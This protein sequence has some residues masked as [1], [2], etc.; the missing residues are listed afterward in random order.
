VLTEVV[1][2]LRALPETEDFWS[3]LMPGWQEGLETARTIVQQGIALSMLRL[4]DPTE[5]SISLVMA[6]PDRGR[7]Y[8]DA[9][10]SRRGF[11]EEKCL[12]VLAA[13]GSASEV[14]HV[15][16]LT[17][18]I[19]RQNGGMVIGRLVGREWKKSR[20]QMP[21]LRDSLWEAGYAVETLE[22]ATKW[23]H[24]MVTGD[25][26]R[27]A[28]THALEHENEPSIIMTHLSHLYRDG[29]SLYYTILF[30]QGRNAE[31]TLA[32]WQRIKEAA[33]QAI[34]SCQATISH[35]HGVGIDHKPYLFAEKGELGI[36]VLETIRGWFDPGE[37]LNPGKLLPEEPLRMGI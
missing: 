1:V 34:V 13:S 2:R 9:I 22:T 31:H 17:N 15:R 8:L 27:Q 35:H 25:Q 33:S 4:S 11:S 16:G 37:L 14:R 21:Y 6:M 30:R 20:F 26:I 7:R 24:I 12:M 23:R 18:Q 10:L 5:T 19:V 29:A 32:R 28:L 36:G 3:A